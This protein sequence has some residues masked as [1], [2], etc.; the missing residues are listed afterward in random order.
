[1]RLPLAY[2]DVRLDAGYRLD[3]AVEELVIVELKT[4]ERVI[5]LHSAQ[6]LSYSRLSGLQIGLLVNFN[7]M[8]LRHGIHRPVH[9]AAARHDS[10]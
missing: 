2:R 7:V 6:L 3:F 9:T 1:V 8:H 4:V 10:G 5:P